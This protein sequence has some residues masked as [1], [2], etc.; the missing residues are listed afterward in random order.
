LTKIALIDLIF[1]GYH[2]LLGILGVSCFYTRIRAGKP[3]LIRFGQINSQ[4]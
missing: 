1:P 4:V 3:I 2:I